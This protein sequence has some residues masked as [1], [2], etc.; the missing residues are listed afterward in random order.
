MIAE[1]ISLDRARRLRVDQS[2]GDKVIAYW[3]CRVCTTMVGVGHTAIESLAVFN[4]F[5]K[6]RREKPIATL[7]V[8]FCPPCAAK[9]H[10]D[11]QLR[12]RGL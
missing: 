6:S 11:D 8:M 4:A 9:W 7:E 10:E 1:I 12:T 3:P 2:V 5:L